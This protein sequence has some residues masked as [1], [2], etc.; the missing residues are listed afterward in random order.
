MLQFLFII[1]LTIALTVMLGPYLQFL[2]QYKWLIMSG[3]STLI[4]HTYYRSKEEVGFV[5]VSTEGVTQAG[6][7][8]LWDNIEK[9]EFDG[10]RAYLRNTDGSSRK[11]KSNLFLVE[12][13]GKLND[14]KIE[15][16]EKIIMSRL[17]NPEDVRICISKKVKRLKPRVWWFIMSLFLS[18]TM[19]FFCYIMQ[20]TVILLIFWGIGSILMISSLVDNYKSL[21]ASYGSTILTKQGDVCLHLEENSINY[22]KDNKCT[23]I[24]WPD[25]KSITLIYDAKSMY[26]FGFT[27]LSIK[28]ID[29]L[30]LPFISQKVVR[31][32][33]KETGFDKQSMNGNSEYYSVK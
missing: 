2:G 23:R 8:V 29:E 12:D 19:L 24:V 9:I 5:D 21:R 1:L 4:V 32:I 6:E 25:I 11:I 3:I 30:V 14:I 20:D 17:P 31:K 33:L 15:A 22:Q 28:E 7:V 16:S 26:D 18:V 10:D 27:V 13:L